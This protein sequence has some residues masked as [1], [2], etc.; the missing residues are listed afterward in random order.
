MVPGPQRPAAAVATTTTTTTTLVAAAA[1]TTRHTAPPFPRHPQQRPHHLCARLCT[2]TRP[3]PAQV[4]CQLV[5]LG[6]PQR[7]S[8]A[9][10]KAR[11]RCTLGPQPAPP[12]LSQTLP[13][14]V[15]SLLQPHLPPP[16]WHQKQHTRQPPPSGPQRHQGA[17]ARH[18]RSTLDTK[19][20][21]DPQPRLAAAVPMTTTDRIW[22]GALPLLQRRHQRQQRGQ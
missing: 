20:G 6:R 4:R 13:L 14:R 16:R 8:C 1:V 7:R 17:D 15:D 2:R 21:R 19:P 22:V 3:C 5:P 12:L 18:P 9:E 11:W 10:A